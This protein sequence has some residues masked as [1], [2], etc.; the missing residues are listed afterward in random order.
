MSCD[1][2]PSTFKWTKIA[3][4]AYCKYE[5]LISQLAPFDTDRVS[6]TLNVRGHISRAVFR[7]LIGVSY[8]GE[9]VREF[10]FMLYRPHDWSKGNALDLYSGGMQLNFGRNTRYSEGLCS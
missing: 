2:L 6:R 3:S 4:N 10:R 7:L 8:Y 9:L 5:A 1:A